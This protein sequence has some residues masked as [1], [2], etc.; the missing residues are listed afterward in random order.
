LLDGI[1]GL[2]RRRVGRQTLRL[3]DVGRVLHSCAERCAQHRDSGQRARPRGVYR[4]AHGETQP[5]NRRWLSPRLL[6]PDPATGEAPLHFLSQSRWR[7]YEIGDQ[8]GTAFARYST[9]AC[10]PPLPCGRPS[11]A[12]PISTTLSVPRIVGALTWPIFAPTFVSLVHVICGR[13]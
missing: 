11:A 1:A 8:A 4:A 7:V 13:H 2:P 3:G 10:A 6:S 9:A 5:D 12:R